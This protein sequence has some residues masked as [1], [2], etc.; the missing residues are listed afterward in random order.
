MSAWTSK[1]RVEG[2]GVWVELGVREERR[3]VGLRR[4][5]R[6]VRVWIG[7]MVWV[8][9]GIVEARLIVGCGWCGLFLVVPV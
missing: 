8:L 5:G 9:S 3:D 7:V 2:I 4:V 6:R 1:R